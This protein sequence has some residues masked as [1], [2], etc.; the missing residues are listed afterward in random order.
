MPFVRGGVRVRGLGHPRVS[1]LGTPPQGMVAVFPPS[2]FQGRQERG[3]GLKTLPAGNAPFPVVH[4]HQCG[5]SGRTRAGFAGPWAR[6]DVRSAALQ[7]PLLTSRSR[8]LWSGVCFRS[9]KPGGPKVKDT[10][11]KSLHRAGAVSCAQDG[12]GPLDGAP[13]DFLLMEGHCFDIKSFLTQLRL[14]SADDWFKE[15]NI[16]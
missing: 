14:D 13:V 11:F 6:A 8:K 15:G 16:R 1:G 7:T 3:G 10:S 4:F 12:S 5:D 2:V 9:Q